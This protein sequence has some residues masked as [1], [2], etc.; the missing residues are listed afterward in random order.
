MS[1]PD[2]AVQVLNLLTQRGFGQRPILL[3]CHSLGGLLAKQILRRAFE[4]TD[5]RQ[6]E[7]FNEARAVLFLATPH[8]GATL[9]SML[10]SFRTVL[11]TTVNA[12]DLRA[13]DAHLRELYD[14]Y[15]NHSSN[16]GI[17]TKTYFETRNVLGFRIVN[18]PSSH[19]D[20]GA[21]PV[22]LDEDHLSIAKPREP[23]AQVCA[24][25]RELLREHVL[26]VREGQAP[27]VL[28]ELRFDSPLHSPEWKLVYPNDPI[29]P[30]YR[31]IPAIGEQPGALYID[32][33]DGN[34][35]DHDMP[36]EHQPNKVD[37][38]AKYT[39]E[40]CHLSSIV[41]E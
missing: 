6:R 20:V 30:K 13:H 4:S 22:P 39:F 35:I 15:R 11:G 37:I 34:P 31:A 40:F 19:P 26:A 12:A 27:A 36:H 9:A 8:V 5:S 25:A 32:L 29:L 2:R 18:E 23:D 14:W 38:V 17:V 33:N 28:Y 21:D 16:S 1:L 24:A 3:V 10:N 7:V 41:R